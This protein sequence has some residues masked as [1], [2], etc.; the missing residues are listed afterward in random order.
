M[1]ALFVFREKLR[2]F[3]GKYDVF[4]TPVVRFVL[5][6]LAFHLINRDLGYMTRL[7]SILVELVLALV[8]SVLPYGIMA[9]L[10][11]LMI[12]AHISS[13]SLELALILAI[14]MV[15]VGILYFGFQPG[16]SYLLVLTPIFFH[17]NIPYAIPLL[18]GLAGHMASAVPVCCGTAMFYIFQYVKQNAGV[19]SG[20]TSA[21][22][23]QRYAQI[24]R[25]LLMNQAMIVMIA[26]CG[27]GVVAVY[28]VRRL[29]V[30]YSWAIAI[31]A[32]VVAQLGMIFMGD[33]VFDVSVPMGSLITSMLLSVVFALV[34]YFMAFAVDYSR[35]EYLQFEDDDYYYYVK[36]VPKI[37]VSMPD[38]KVQ[39][40]SRKEPEYLDEDLPDD[41]DEYLK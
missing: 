37:S 22:L 18:V 28:L 15:I 40:F 36:A 26:A 30:N 11:A 16:D 8:C 20:D 9:F 33:Y 38:V 32:G 5:G 41:D 29:S 34:Y 24:V 1:I 23:I 27:A 7:N 35:T 21:E 10:A 39:R 4:I 19:L 6:F 25:S 3:Y 17:Y 31:A 13:V 2:G 12:L 14:L